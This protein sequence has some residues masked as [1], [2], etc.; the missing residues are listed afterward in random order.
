M[1]QIMN[2][3]A[4]TITFI[5]HSTVLIDMGGVKVLTDPVFSN[6]IAIINKR[7]QSPGMTIEQLPPL[8]AVIISHAHYDHYDYPTL[9]QIDAGRPVIFPQR[10]T[11]FNRSLKKRHVVELDHWQTWEKDAL[12]ITAVPA[13]HFNGRYII[14]GLFRISTGYVLEHNPYAVYFAGDTA[15]SGFFKEI[16]NRF[17]LDIALLPIGSYRPSLIMRWNHLRPEE[18][19]MAFEDTGADYLMPIHWGTFR[20]SLEPLHEPIA[21]L[22][23][24]MAKRG[25][26]DRVIIRQPGEA[27]R[28]EKNKRS[29][30]V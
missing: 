9:K 20:L 7:H 22:N 21:R 28:L 12:K 4:L 3:S 24:I 19:V 13:K 1:R 8:D 29:G 17:N 6:R 5:G 27:W 15:Y 23:Q 14:D 10:T 25:I 11:C 2:T 18:T 16:G 26:T 30:A